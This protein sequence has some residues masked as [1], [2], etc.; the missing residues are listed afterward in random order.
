MLS[1]S[2]IKDLQKLERIVPF[3]TAYRERLNDWETKPLETP[4]ALRAF[5]WQ[6]QEFRI[7]VFAPE[8]G[9]ASKVSEKR[10]TKALEDLA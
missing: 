5:G 9:T 10:L 3:E 4:M 1:A 7:A 6:L 2:S 8:V